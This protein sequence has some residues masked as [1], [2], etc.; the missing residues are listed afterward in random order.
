M[1]HSARTKIPLAPI[2]VLAPVSAHMQHF[3]L[4]HIDTSGDFS[5]M[6]LQQK[7]SK[8]NPAQAREGGTPNLFTSNLIFRELKQHVR[9]S[10]EW[11]LYSGAWT[12]YSGAWRLYSG[13][14]RLYS[15]AWRL[16]SGTWQ[17]YS[18]AWQLYSCAWRLYS[19]TNQ[20]IL[21]ATT[22]CLQRPRTA[23]AVG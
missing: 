18:C 11:H 2:G 10:G 9:Y 14:W 16:Y 20:V 6:C 23:H 5:C 3:A 15:D 13:E 17:L 7:P 21:I 8:S 22:F 12:L 19:P 1:T 4:P